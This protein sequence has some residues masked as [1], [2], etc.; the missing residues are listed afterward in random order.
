MTAAPLARLQAE[1]RRNRRL[2]LGGLS[3]L[4]ILGLQ[5]VLQLSDARAARIEQYDRDA[6]L[7]SRLEEASR[8]AAWPQRAVATQAA[9]TAVRATLPAASSEGLAQA[10]LQAWLGDLAVFAGIGN[11]SVRVEPALAVDGEPE[12]WQV[13]ARL[14][15]DMSE[16]QAAL[17]M[18]TLAQAQPWYQTERLQLQGGAT[19][20]V[21]LVLRGYYRKVEG[22][23]V[24]SARPANLPSADAA[25]SAGVPVA[26]VRRNPLAPADAKAVSA[27]RGEQGP[28]Q[29]ERPRNPLAPP[30]APATLPAAQPANLLP[31][32]ASAPPTRPRNPLAPRD[33][34]GAEKAR[35]DRPSRNRGFPPREG[36]RQRRE[37]SG[38]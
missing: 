26:P 9:L 19:P 15:G 1:W 10:E 28:R 32:P 11:P 6:K 2:R 17:L 34:G 36:M 23:R 3:I 31:G 13:L 33:A 18:R 22:E 35:A 25:R 29:R 16:T 5:L 12:L 4:A 8:E 21:S 37:R 38:Q 14:E 20:R 24:A 27:V 30:G 7:L